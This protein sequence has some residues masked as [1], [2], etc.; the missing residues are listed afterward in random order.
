M[1]KKY[2]FCLTV[3]SLKLKA[4]KGFS[5]IELIV[6]LFIINFGMLGVLSLVLQ[7][8]KVENTNKNALIAAQLTQEGIELVRNTRDNNW[9]SREDWKINVANYNNS[10]TYVVDYLNANNK[11]VDKIDNVDARLYLNNSGYYTHDSANN[12]LTI[13][14]RLISVSEH[15]I[16]TSAST[17][18]DIKST[19]RWKE[20]GNY[21]DYIAEVYLY[22][23]KN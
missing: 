6:C 23:W 19:V 21:H 7:N 10:P 5:L 15:K 20:R 4:T 1:K 13:F 9:L 2:F 22:D 12:S 14:S 11:A 18:L 8:I 3:N 17:Y 16:A